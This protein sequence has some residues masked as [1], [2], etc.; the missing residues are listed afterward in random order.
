MNFDWLGF[1]KYHIDDQ[2]YKSEAKID[3]Y[4]QVMFAWD[5]FIDNCW[6]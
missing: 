5:K 3:V 2:V 6:S 1:A 4:N